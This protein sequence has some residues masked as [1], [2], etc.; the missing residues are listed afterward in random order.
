MSGK[1]VAWAVAGVTTGVIVMGALV[2]GGLA[3]FRPDLPETAS[4]PPRFL[5]ESSA[6][7]LDHVYDGEFQYFVGGGVAVLDC[8]E[9]GWPDLYLA[10]GEGSDSLY[11]NI[12]QVG[13][14]LSF[15]EVHG[16]GT[17]LTAV[18]GAYPI[19]IDSD[20]HTDLA[21][22]RVGEDVLLR[23]LGD[24]VFEPSNEK[25]SIEAAD[26]WTVGFSATWEGASSFPTMAFGNY[27]AEGG[28][29]SGEC[30]DHRLFR[31][32]DA[33]SGPQ[34]PAQGYGR[35]V[36]LSPGFCTLSI[37]FS[38]WDRSGRRDLRMT[39]DRHYYRNGEEQLWRV[40]QGDEPRL[41]TR[42]DGWQPMQIW[43]MGIAG[44]DVTGDGLPEYF[45]TSQGDNKLQTLADGPSQPE[46][47]D[48]A[49][50]RGLTA[51]RPY[52]GDVSAPSTA[53]HPEFEDVNNDSLVDLFVSK[54]NVE[55]QVGYAARDPSNLLLGNPDG[56]FTEAAAQAGIVDFA[57]SRGA[58]LADFNLDGM[59]DLVEV[60]RRENVRL[61]RNVGWGD[62]AG[63][64]EMGNWVALDLQQPAP[65]V[66]AIGS[67][68]ELRVG[69]RVLEKEITI[70]GGHAGGQLG[71]AHFGVGEADSVEVRV[72]WPD[73]EKGRWVEVG[74]N[75][76]AIIERD[77]PEAVVWD[78]AG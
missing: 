14:P 43:G 75:Q 70:G 68:V 74:T 26:D 50:E 28:Q 62:E 11:R 8:D 10:G 56:T 67:W 34:S 35:P 39:N 3:L 71:W 42:E 48:I 51:H 69:N 77:A 13:G 5:E 19:D 24:C 7:G 64:R 65:N 21:V 52:A 30:E 73:G 54:G 78:P 47:V 23:G 59:L 53:W 16:A 32:E 37:L 33:D 63:P 58:A 55:S 61:W 25:W 29:T 9:D 57:R 6:A 45:L 27:L 36:S 72:Q 44:R 20:N 40:A 1:A 49:F 41:Y 22:L 46:Y 38:D 18:T 15:A 76:F 12:S 66:D 60:T 17:G 2:L 4:P 31:P